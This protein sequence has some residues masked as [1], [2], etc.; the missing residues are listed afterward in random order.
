MASCLKHESS[1]H[2]R[3]SCSSKS[4]RNLHL[5]KLVEAPNKF[6]LLLLQKRWINGDETII[7]IFIYQSNH[8]QILVCIRLLIIYQYRIS[9]PCA[10]PL[11]SATCLFLCHLCSSS[12]FSWSTFP[13]IVQLSSALGW[14]YFWNCKNGLGIKLK[15]ELWCNA[16]QSS[17][18][19]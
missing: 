3:N 6:F 4:L 1:S 16:T 12:S 9:I 7:V 18:W 15:M 10:V 8:V 2:P 11:I 17:P 5:N 14:I 13:V 19:K